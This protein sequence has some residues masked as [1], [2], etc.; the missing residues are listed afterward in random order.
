MSARAE[1]E[2]NKGITNHVS[3][4]FCDVPLGVVL[5][6]IFSPEILE[7]LYGGTRVQMTHL[8]RPNAFSE[9]ATVLPHGD[10]E[11]KLTYKQRY[12][13]LF[14]AVKIP[15]ATAGNEFTATCRVWDVD[16]WTGWG[17]QYN[18]YRDLKLRFNVSP[19][20]RATYTV[21]Q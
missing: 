9:E 19:D 16:E 1:I 5:H 6:P 21:L 15:T 2:A 12:G 14:D 18:E 20:G 4:V 8:Y 3:E 10:V 11:V 17:S 7:A 13:S